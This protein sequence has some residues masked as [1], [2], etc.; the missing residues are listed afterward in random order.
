ML[1]SLA[2]MLD[3]TPPEGTDKTLPSRPVEM[4]L[5]CNPISRGVDGGKRLGSTLK[6]VSLLL[7]RIV[8]LSSSFLVRIIYKSIRAWL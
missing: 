3:E 5:F 1:G 4:T 7:F 2:C 8:P 6:V